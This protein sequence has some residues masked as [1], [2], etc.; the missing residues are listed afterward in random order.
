M[1][2]HYQRRRVGRGPHVFSKQDDS[3]AIKQREI[4]KYMLQELS[5]K[6]KAVRLLAVLVCVSLMG[7]MLVACGGA[8]SPE[9]S[10]EEITAIIDKEMDNQLNPS[11]EMLAAD[12]GIQELE[13]LGVSAD[14][15]LSEL[16][17][18]ASYSIDDISIDGNNATATVSVVVKPLGGFE[19][20]FNGKLDTLLADPEA[21][22]G[23]NEEEV[24]ALAMGLAIEA[25]REIPTDSS[26]LELP[27]ELA[28]GAW[29]KGTEF[30]LIL[31]NGILA[32]MELSA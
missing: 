7:T 1:L 9:Q 5:R 24:T 32:G 16:L 21:L 18:G 2:Y 27:L 23:L 3:H 22:Q 14:D 4:G 31:Y 25:L 15:F 30:D 13:S 10:K 29:K 17:D 6:A 8:M 20:A 28:N 12:P 26:T 11:S 19:T